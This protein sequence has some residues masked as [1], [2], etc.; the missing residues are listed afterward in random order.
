MIIDVKIMSS[1]LQNQKKTFSKSEN[2]SMK[3]CGQYAQKIGQM[4]TVTQ[5]KQSLQMNC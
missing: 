5:Q 4:A 3:P 2:V 1:G